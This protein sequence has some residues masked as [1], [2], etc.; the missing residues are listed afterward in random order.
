MGLI[1]SDEAPL[2]VGDLIGM[3]VI[4]ILIFNFI[5]CSILLFCTNLFHTHSS[6]AEEEDLGFPEELTHSSPMAPSLPP[7]QYSLT[8]PPP[9]VQ[10][11]DLPDVEDGFQVVLQRL[12]GVY[13][14]VLRREEVMEEVEEP[15]LY[16]R[17]VP[18]R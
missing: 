12:D 8:P 1:H 14:T 15:P 17:E 2:N 6:E 4:C 9:Y 11:V 13:S 5:L 7:S 10:S 3:V 16:L 18:R